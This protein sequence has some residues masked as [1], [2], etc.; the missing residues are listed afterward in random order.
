[1]RTQAILRRTLKPQATPVFDDR[2]LVARVRYVTL[3]T[4][5][6]CLMR[7]GRSN[8]AWRRGAPL[9]VIDWDS[10]FLVPRFDADHGVVP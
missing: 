7:F 8:Q 6:R 3:F 10:C 1:M 9:G 2:E 4:D 5:P